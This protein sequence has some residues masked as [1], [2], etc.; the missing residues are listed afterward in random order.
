MNFLLEASL[1]AG[2]F[3]LLTLLALNITQRE[4]LTWV[5][6]G[7]LWSVYMAYSLYSSHR[8]INQNLQTHDDIDKVSNQIVSL[9]FVIMILLQVVNA[10]LWQAFAPLLAALIVNLAGA[11]L[12]FTRLIRSAFH[13]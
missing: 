6:T 13:D 7:S 9:A 12:Q 5:T 1:T 8:R 11:A 10:L 2:G 4:G 3:A